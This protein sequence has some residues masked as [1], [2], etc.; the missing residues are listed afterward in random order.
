MSTD[1]QIRTRSD[2]IES[3]NSSNHSSIEMNNKN[4]YVVL[5]ETS[6]REFESWYYFIRYEGMTCIF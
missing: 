1:K 3:D 6:G 2:S 4:N 5:C